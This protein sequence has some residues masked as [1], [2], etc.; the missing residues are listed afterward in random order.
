MSASG[1]PARPDLEGLMERVRPALSLSNE[2]GWFAGH[3]IELCEFGLALEAAEARLAATLRASDD[4]LAGAREI[5]QS[6]YALCHHSVY[7]DGCSRCT[8]KRALA[9]LGSTSW[10]AQHTVDGHRGHCPC[11]L[12]LIEAEGKLVAALKVVEA[13][14]GYVLAERLWL[15]SG[16]GSLH[17]R[18]A[19]KAA[20]D[21]RAAVQEWEAGAT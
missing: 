6:D 21:L 9:R 17:G 18:G 8:V 19:D 15:E 11:S 12:D 4:A 1:E 13:A 14:Q 10:T 7:N 3:V 2:Q 20:A 5:L 16:M